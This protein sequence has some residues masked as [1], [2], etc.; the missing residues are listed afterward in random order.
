MKL[1]V[2]DTVSVMDSRITTSPCTV[3]E[4]KGSI[5]LVEDTSGRIHELFAD[6]VQKRMLF[7]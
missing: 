3:V 5:L 2:G 7:G 1:R 6:Q 4:I